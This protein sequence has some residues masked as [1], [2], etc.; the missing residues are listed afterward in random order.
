MFYLS[1]NNQA[2]GIEALNSTSKYLDYLRNIDNHYFKQ[3][4]GQMNST[5]LQ[6][7]K[8]N[9]FDSETPFLT[10]TCL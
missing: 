3:M 9:S 5:K 7:N 4:V 8:A 1:N 6:L 10:W 2:T